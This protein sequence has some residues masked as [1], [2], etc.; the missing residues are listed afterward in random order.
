M[1]Y[2]MDLV[3][4]GLMVG[5]EDWTLVSL[6]SGT[7]L[8]HRLVGSP[9]SAWKGIILVYAVDTEYYLSVK[10]ARLGSL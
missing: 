9:Y 2:L 6:G 10:M 4:F 8:L 1:Q 5:A 3:G 7:N